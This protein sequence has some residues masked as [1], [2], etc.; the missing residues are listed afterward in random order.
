MQQD[1]A[2][3]ALNPRT[4]DKPQWPELSEKIAATMAHEE[5]FELDVP[6]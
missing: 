6:F 4:Y 5:I 2:E 3:N 1:T